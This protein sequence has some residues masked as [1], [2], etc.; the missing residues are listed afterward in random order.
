[1]N[2]Y[3]MCQSFVST[4]GKIYGTVLRIISFGQFISR[5]VLLHIVKIPLVMIVLSSIDFRLV[6]LA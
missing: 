4:S 3:I 6:I 1:V 5:L 2:L